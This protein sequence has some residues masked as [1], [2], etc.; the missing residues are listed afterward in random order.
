M[1]KTGGYMNPDMSILYFV[2]VLLLN[3]ASLLLHE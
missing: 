1:N 3:A 2:R